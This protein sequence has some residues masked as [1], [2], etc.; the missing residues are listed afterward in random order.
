MSTS[1]TKVLEAR[2]AAYRD[3][4]EELKASVIAAIKANNGNVLAT[5]RL[6]NLP[7]DTVNYW[8][9]HSER[10]VELE[11]TSKLNLADKLEQIA[12]NTTDSLADHDLSIVSYRDKA[13]SL[14]VIIDRMQLLRG[15]PT[16]I[17]GVSEADRQLR[18]AELL[19]RLES[20]GPAGMV[21]DVTPEP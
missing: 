2:S 14:A 17:A 19:V 1:E 4:P 6:F 10:F 16:T 12:H 9:R 21:I 7:R 20:R 15:E 3:Y 11:Q 8:W 5:S 18:L 13:S